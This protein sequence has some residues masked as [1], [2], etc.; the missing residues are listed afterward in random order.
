MRNNATGISV[1]GR[2][3]GI[4]RVWPR[5]GEMGDHLFAGHGV[6]DQPDAAGRHVLLGVLAV[7]RFDDRG[8]EGGQLGEQRLAETRG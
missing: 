6:G 7:D 2:R 4:F 1:F 8:E 3:V 5:V